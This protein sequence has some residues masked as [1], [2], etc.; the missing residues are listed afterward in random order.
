MLLQI[1]GDE[2][3]RFMASVRDVI[4]CREDQCLLVANHMQDLDMQGVMVGE[5]PVVVVV[6]VGVFSQ[7]R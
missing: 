2:N 4:D 6:L 5:A 1:L 7:S 3:S